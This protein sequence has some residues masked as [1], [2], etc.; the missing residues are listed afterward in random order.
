MNS[1]FRL[2]MAW[3]H[4]WAGVIL[5]SIMFVMFFMGTLSVFKAEIDLWML[6][7][8]RI[9]AP[10]A[11]ISADAIYEKAKEIAGKNPRSIYFVMPSEHF[12]AIP[13]YIFDAEGTR[14]DTFVD[15]NT[16]EE[17]RPTDS[18]SARY[19]LYPMHYR[20]TP[21]PYGRWF[22]AA[23]AMFML[24][25]MLSGVVIHRKIFVDFFTFRPNR[26][27]PRSSLDLHNITSV[28]AL[29]FHIFITLTGVII[30]FGLYFQPTLKAAYPDADNPRFE[31]RKDVAGSISA[32][33]TGRIV[34]AP[35]ASIDEM[36]RIAAP[37]WEGQPLAAVYLDRPHDEGGVV[38]LYKSLSAQ[39]SAR[40]ARAAFNPHTGEL[41]SAPRTTAGY[42]VQQWLS[43]MHMIFFDHW[44]LR[45]LYFIGGAAGCI[46]VATGFVYWLETRR[47]KYERNRW[48]GVRIVEGFAV[49]GVMGLMTA[50]AAF[51]V[52][53]RAL[54]PGVWEWNGIPKPYLEPLTF[55]A[56]WLGA[57]F[58]GWIR[59][60]RAWGEQAWL[61]GALGVIAVLLNWIT[62][63]DHLATTLARGYW[64]V[65]G[66]DLIL[67]AGAGVSFLA[68]RK[69]GAA[70]KASKA[71]SQ[72]ALKEAAAPAE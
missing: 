17:T 67:L 49:W 23:A 51:F 72:R 69:I 8:T 15:P 25:M 50:T 38:T 42:E 53:N 35:V 6:P 44:V 62:T 28:F 58:H 12:P 40:D 63:G 66:M 5:G 10:N 70:Q 48:P 7:Q 4:T 24:L 21:L 32:E 11:P 68:A 31:I 65:A 56:V 27:L 45:W 55:Y 26:K 9:E 37:Y 39:V 57:M 20:L 3:L 59:G 54:A 14:I 47:K 41:L 19:F 34:D 60:K 2:S 61:L 71:I 1:D 36:A 33:E 13:V 22:S 52:A 29:P 43:G 16:M 46:M 64:P 18:L 30:L